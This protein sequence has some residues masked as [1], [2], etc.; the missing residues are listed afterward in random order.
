MTI[1]DVDPLMRPI[2]QDWHLD[3]RTRGGGELA[4]E[5]REQVID[6]GIARW[7][8]R[9]QYRAH[10]RATVLAI[11]AQTWRLRGRLNF[12]KIG[13]CDCVNGGR[14]GGIIGG[15]PYSQPFGY[16]ATHTDGTGF[17]QGG[18][19]PTV[20]APAAARNDFVDLK[21]NNSSGLVPGIYLGLGDRLY[22][23]IDAVS[24]GNGVRRL[25][26]EPG[27]REA[28]TTAT[29]VRLCDA[30][31]IMRAVVDD[32]GRLELELSRFGT[33]TFDLVESY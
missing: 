11:R 15:I 32:T 26:I 14:I 4:I 19:G 12:L 33:A 18:V 10:N 23:V 17:S 25:F 21:V 7:V 2:V 3:V 28:I 22:G 24:L 9:I 30:R 6:S 20:N 27:L 31:T 16:T 8:A 1:W 29:P 13:P 5:G